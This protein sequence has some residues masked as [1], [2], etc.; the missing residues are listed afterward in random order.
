VHLDRILH[1]G[2]FAQTYDTKEMMGV[3]KLA[4]FSTLQNKRKIAA[5]SSLQ[6]FL[7]Q[8]CR[9]CEKEGPLSYASHFFYTEE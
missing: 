8:F 2:F 4:V 3:G 5:A 1:C 7:S 6:G 9:S